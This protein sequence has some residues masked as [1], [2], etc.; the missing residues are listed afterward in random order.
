MRKNSVEAETVRIS[1]Y[2]FEKLFH[3]RNTN[4]NPTALRSAK[5]VFR[6]LFTNSDVHSQRQTSLR[7][8][9]LH[10]MSTKLFETFTPDY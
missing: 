7:F 2:L 10:R 1:R 5:I 3:I 9:A 6:Q 8:N 4:V